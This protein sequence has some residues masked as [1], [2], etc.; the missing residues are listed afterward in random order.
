MGAGIGIYNL[1]R[2]EEKKSSV[3]Y[4]PVIPLSIGPLS[5]IFRSN[6]SSIVFKLNFRW[7]VNIIRRVRSDTPHC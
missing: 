5:S 6:V 7:Y 4:P 3:W 2:E 1:I